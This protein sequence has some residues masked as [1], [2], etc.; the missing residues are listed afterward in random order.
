MKMLHYVA[1]L[2]L[3]LVGCSD[4]SA[5]PT[6]DM[7]V[8]APIDI[9]PDQSAPDI[10]L[11]DMTV[12]DQGMDMEPDAPIDPPL[13]VVP[14]NYCELTAESFCA[15]YLRCGRIAANDMAE[16][17][18]LFDESCNQVYEPYYVAHARE[19]LMELSTQGIEACALH[20]E[21]V[22][23]EDQIFDLDGG[24]SDV[25]KGLVPAGGACGPGISSFVCEAGTTC[26]LNLQ[27]CGT[28]EPTSPTGG[29]CLGDSGFRCDPLDRCVE[30]FC[31]ARGMPGD[32][33]DDNSPCRLGSSCTE[34]ICRGV[35]VVEIGESC[36]QAR[37]CPYGSVCTAG[38]CVA[39]VGLD[40]PC[41]PGLCYSGHCDTTDN[42]C[43]ALRPGGAQCTASP[44]CQSGICD[45]GFCRTLPGT[46]FQ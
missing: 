24:C 10:S 34:G 32:V 26:I 21:S 44:Q 17:L 4:D 31:V 36:D 27:F 8:D 2:A 41:S 9:T 6:S 42:V 30:G 12:V 29:P 15:Y 43:R 5:S 39:Q 45:N 11:P 40:Q 38:E 16:C 3:A 37:R 14:E 1:V 23:C 25:W 19:G 33:C 20:L 13:E 28:C 18:A 7:G 46:C 22:A 35:N